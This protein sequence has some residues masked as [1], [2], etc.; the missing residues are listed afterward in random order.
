MYVRTFDFKETG[1]YVNGDDRETPYF[2]LF[3]NTNANSNEKRI[4]VQDEWFLK[5]TLIQVWH[6]IFYPDGH[7]LVIHPKPEGW[8]TLF[9]PFRETGKTALLT[10]EQLRLL[11]CYA[12]V[13]YC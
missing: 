11:Y 10:K 7:C 8:F 6:P 5:K 1:M 13:V 2:V 4:W 9:D 12:K 3:E